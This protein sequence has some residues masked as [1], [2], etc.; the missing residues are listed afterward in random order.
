MSDEHR[1]RLSPPG[2]PPP[3]SGG[4]P[5]G[6]AGGDLGGDYP[7]PSVVKVGGT[8]INT[9]VAPVAGATWVYDSVS[10]KMILRVP[11]R[12]F[13]SGALAAAAAPLLNGTFVVLN[14]GSPTSEA[15]TYQVATNQGAAFPGD[16]TK[17]SDSTDTAS[18]V[19]IVDTGNNYAESD[20][21]G[22]LAAIGGGSILPQ[23]KAV[24]M[25]DNVLDR[26]VSATYGT[27]VWIVTMVKGNLRLVTTLSVAH[28]GTAAVIVQSGTV[29]G[30]G[31]T[32]P[33]FTF[34]AAL[35]DTDLCLMVNATD[36]G[37]S[38]RVRRIALF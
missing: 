30:P 29:V 13:A 36:T 1:S 37:W 31:I 18:E 22:A 38:G 24:A 2:F 27:G 3:S 17:I 10:G 16:Y 28:N 19:G 15:G 23:I 7:N 14:P 5:T 32:T 25:G 12:Y 21:E 33:P 20:V 4:T 6:A 34:D 26:V 8:P 11:F 9:L 35:V